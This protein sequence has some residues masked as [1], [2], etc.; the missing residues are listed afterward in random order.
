MSAAL[1]GHKPDAVFIATWSRQANEA[2]NIRVNAAMVRNL[3]DALRGAGSVGHVALV[4]G[5]KHYLGP[6][7]AY[8][9]G[10]LTA[11][12]QVAADELY[13]S[14]SRVTVHSGDTV[15][16][17]NEG[18]TAG[19]QSIQTGAVS[20]RQACAD[21]RALFLAQAAQIMGCNTSELSVRD[22]SILRNGTSTGQDYWTLAS[23]IDLTAK[24]TGTGARK[25]VADFTAIGHDTPRLDLPP[26]IFG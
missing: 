16:A 9:Q 6:F 8:G 17:P 21:V 4:T 14:L 23:A 1:A 13:V 25:A 11:M 7:E 3:L 10:V 22:G 5:L 26:K 18:Y 15:R 2:E 12:L 19:S 20:L 24:A